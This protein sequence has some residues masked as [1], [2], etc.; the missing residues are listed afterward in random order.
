MMRIGIV[1]LGLIGGSLGLALKAL[2]RAIEVVGVARTPEGAVAAQGFGAVDRGSAELAALADADLVVVATPIHQIA[3]VLDRLGAVLPP[4]TLIT[5]VGSVKGSV[6]SSAQRL[7]EPG[8]FLGGHPVAG[9][10]HSGL[11]ESDPG[12]FRGEAWIFT[13]AEGQDVRRFDTWFELVRAI[14]ARPVFMT[15]RTHDE[16]MAFLS[17]LAFTLSAAYAE[18]VRDHADPELAGPGYRGMVRLAAGDPSMYEDIA[19]ENREPLVDAM[20]T[21]TRVFDRYRERIEK[22]VRVHEL[23]SAGQHVAV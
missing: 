12:I 1:G 20:D 15:P 23:F 10:A 8:R 16:Q 6:V 14:G 17:H 18:S 11:A 2:G 19:R 9:K 13:P 21:F 22:G 5:D 3:P 7:P 4:S